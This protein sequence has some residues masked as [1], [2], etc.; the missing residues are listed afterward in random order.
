MVVNDLNVC[1]PSGTAHKANAPLIIDT[2]AMLTG[3]VI[4]ER[5]QPVARRCAQKIECQGGV[6]LRQFS[7]SDFCNGSKAFRAFPLE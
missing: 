3:S 5:L 7:L 2:D 6:Q 1:R 4:F